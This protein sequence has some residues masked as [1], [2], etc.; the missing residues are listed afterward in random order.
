MRCGIACLHSI[1][2][3][4]TLNCDKLSTINSDADA[5]TDAGHAKRISG[6]RHVQAFRPDDFHKIYHSERRAEPATGSP[7]EEDAGVCM[8]THE[9]CAEWAASG[10][11][12]KNPMYMRGEGSDSAGACRLACGLCQA[13]AV[14]DAACYHNNRAKAGYLDLTQEVF[15][16]TGQHLPVQ[17]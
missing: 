1:D 7:R 16:L 15:Q 2:A 14:G 10:E 17:F 3:C 5:V 13:C 12:S 6:S 9:K 11:C 8:D 4:S